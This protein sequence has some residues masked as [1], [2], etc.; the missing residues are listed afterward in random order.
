MLKATLVS[1]TTHVQCQNKRKPSSG[2]KIICPIKLKS[3]KNSDFYVV[4]MSC[5]MH[6]IFDYNK[7]VAFKFV[8][9]RCVFLN[10]RFMVYNCLSQSLDGN[11]QYVAAKCKVTSTGKII[12]LPIYDCETEKQ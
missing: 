9:G 7:N 12:V 8:L 3:Q 1:T 11:R 5:L 4:I 6:T 2:T 10:E